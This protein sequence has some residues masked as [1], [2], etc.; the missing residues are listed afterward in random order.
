MRR[1]KW[2]GPVVF[3]Q[4]DKC[5]RSS[6]TIKNIPT[7]RYFEITPKDVGSK[8]IVHSGNKLVEVLVTNDMKGHKFGEFVS[9]K[10][11]TVLKKR[12]GTKE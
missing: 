12:S 5:D 2:K 6:K 4:T 8:F 9:T 7:K 1:V 11:I 3:N 10:K